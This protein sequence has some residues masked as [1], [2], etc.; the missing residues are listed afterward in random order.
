MFSDDLAWW[1]YLLI[2]IV[3][4]YGTVLFSYWIVHNRFK[5]S[6]VFTYTLIW[7]AGTTF[8]GI[9][10]MYARGLTLT[11]PLLF[12]EFSQSIWWPFRKVAIIIILIVFMTHMTLRFLDRSNRSEKQ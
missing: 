11:D 7:L 8:N 1:L 9:I 10:N 12:A 4:G 3:S 5:A 6:A 2:T